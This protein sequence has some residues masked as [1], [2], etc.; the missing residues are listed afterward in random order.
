LLEVV[1]ATGVFAFAAALFIGLINV[2]MSFEAKNRNLAEGMKIMEDFG[3][4]VEISSFEDIKK[5]NNE[6]ATLYAAEE[7]EDDIVYRKFMTKSDWEL[8]DD[9]KRLG[10]AVEIKP[11]GALFADENPKERYYIPL[12]CRLLKINEESHDLISSD[13]GENF[14]TFVTVKNY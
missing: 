11:M 10:Y 4:F 2:Q 12:T 13:I 3:V 9:S 1:L 8:V 5:L 14:S 7:E 6:H